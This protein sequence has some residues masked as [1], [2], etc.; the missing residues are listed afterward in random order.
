MRAKGTL[1]TGMMSHTIITGIT[2]GTMIVTTGI[3]IMITG[4]AITTEGITIIGIGIPIA[5][6]THGEELLT[7]SAEKMNIEH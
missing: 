7:S 2:A 5:T 1:I 4:I 3:M 6:R